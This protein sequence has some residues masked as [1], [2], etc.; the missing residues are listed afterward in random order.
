MLRHINLDI[1]PGESIALVGP[2]GGG[3][4]TMCNLIPR[5][6]EP[7]EGEI[8]I[9]GTNIRSYTLKSLR[10]QIG[11]VMQDVYMF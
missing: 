9:D 1:K 10:S 5:F 2:S 3:K 11:V 6:Y 4:T 7:S 8:S